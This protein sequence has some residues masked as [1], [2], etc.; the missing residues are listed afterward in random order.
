[1]E[2]RVLVLSLL[3]APP[4]LAPAPRQ[5][6]LPAPIPVEPIA[7][8]T[9][10]FQTHEIVAL[11]DPHGNEQV[12]KLLLSLIAD[13]R[14]PAVAQDIVLEAASA[15]YQDVL[16]RYVR[17]DSVPD[18]SLRL[19]W[20]EHTVPNSLGIH[21]S[22]LI[23]TVRRVNA[24]LPSVQRFRVLG[25]DPPIDWE[26]VVTVQDHRRW[27]ELRDSYPA[28]LIRRQVLDRGRKALVVY[29]QGHLQPAMIETNYDTAAWQARTLMTLITSDP[30]VRVFNVFTVLRDA[31]AVGPLFQSWPVPSLVHLP[32]TS[33][34]AQ[35]FAGLQ[36]PLGGQRLMLRDGK[37][38][39]IPR[40]AWQARPLAHQF[41]ALLY[42]GHPETFT[43]VGMPAELCRDVPFIRRRLDRLARFGP[44]PELDR[45]KTACGVP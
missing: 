9:A 33:L 42:L 16:D 40:D 5:P 12:Q 24:S 43:R 3:L 15:R 25:G 38:V 18:S 13:P 11:T 37:P 23:R 4:A 2:L 36:P 26:N 34:G 32:G 1:M 17:G 44:K 29:G 35:D 10:A 22:E 8:L 27:I 19:V 20:E 21:A 7:A 41:D 6:E 31:E 39:P 45:L 14:L 28:D 30:Q